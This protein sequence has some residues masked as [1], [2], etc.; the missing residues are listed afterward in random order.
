[1]AQ[2]RV[3]EPQDLQHVH[4]MHIQSKNHVTFMSVV[5]NMIIVY[6][7]VTMVTDLMRSEAQHGVV[8]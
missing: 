7:T 2:V 5:Y 6:V 4:L 8:E 3:C 1:M